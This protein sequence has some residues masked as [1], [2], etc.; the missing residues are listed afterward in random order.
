MESVS[1]DPPK[2]RPLEKLNNQLK[3]AG[4]RIATGVQGKVDALNEGFK[5]VKE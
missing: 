2:Q 3:Q 4:S 1:S 5:N